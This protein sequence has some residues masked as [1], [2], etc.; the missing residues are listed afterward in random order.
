MAEITS[1]PT[2]SPTEQWTA[3][4]ENF[5]YARIDETIAGKNTSD[6]V[7]ATLLNKTD[8]YTFPADGPSKMKEV[9]EVWINIYVNSTDAG[10]T[11]GIR[12]RLYAG[13]V[14]KGSRSY[15]VDT[16]GSWIVYGL[17][18][19]GLSL[20]RAEYNDLRV[21]ST[22]IDGAGQLVPEAP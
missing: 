19:T 20:T 4:P 15:R 11:P 3:T 8:L 16:S 1:Q 12:V 13:A 5:N 2:G 22:S 7:R 21:E 10:K 9:T 17:R 18:F 6:Y 14:I